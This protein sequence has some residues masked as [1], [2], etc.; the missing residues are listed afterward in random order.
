MTRR[1]WAWARLL[2]GAA[3]LT[4]LAW[5]VGV[6][7][8]IDG[9]TAIDARALVA[10]GVITAF[11]TVC[12]AWRWRLVAGGLGARLSMGV[13]TA[14][15]YRSQFLN[16]TLPGGILGDVHR[17][18]R[19]GRETGDVGRGLRAALWD[20][21][22]GQTVQIAAT[23]LLLTVLPSP[24]RAFMPTVAAGAVV[25]AVIA[26]GLILGLRTVPG[27]GQSWWARVASTIS[28][29][30]RHGLLGKGT[31]PGVVL[32]SLAAVAGHLAIFLIAARAAG[33]SASPGQMVGLGLFVLAAMS[34][35]VNIAGWGLREGAAAWAFAAAGLGAGQGI[36]VAVAYGVLSLAA[37]L[38]GAVVLVVG[39]LRRHHAVSAQP[40][41]AAPSNPAAPGRGKVSRA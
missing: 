24:V 6:G 28:A 20:R 1:M 30:I 19:S 22:G 14:S 5:R 12:C 33:V 36:A 39:W 41:E 21:V 8:F 16:S 11:T 38:P 40:S 34:V 32:S 27:D 26:V 7:P 13:A 31:W 4:V 15:Y 18:A 3:V 2:G 9:V 17:G 25:A 37:C 29:D 23:I 10:A 35:P